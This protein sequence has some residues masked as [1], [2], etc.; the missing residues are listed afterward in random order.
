MLTSSSVLGAAL[1]VVLPHIVLRS[2]R[3]GVIMFCSVSSWTILIVSG[4]F[5]W[6]CLTTDDFD[7][8]WDDSCSGLLE[9]LAREAE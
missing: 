1:C 9:T 3:C 5:E 4:W 2:V 7:K 8:E 6:I